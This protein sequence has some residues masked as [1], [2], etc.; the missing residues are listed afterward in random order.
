M[1]E[2]PDAVVLIFTARLFDEHPMITYLST[3]LHWLLPAA[4]LLV[5]VEIHRPPNIRGV[6]AL[7]GR[8][9]F[10]LVAG[11][12]RA[13][14]GFGMLLRDAHA[15]VALGPTILEQLKT[16]DPNLA[17]RALVVPP[18]PLVA[19]PR[20]A[21]AQSRARSRAQLG[22][23]EDVFLLAYFGYVYPG[24]GIETLLA[25]LRLLLDGGRKVCLVM[26]GGGRGLRTDSGGGAHATYE[27]EMVG[28]AQRLGIA[29]EVF[30][31]QGYASGSEDVALDLLAADAAVLPFDDGAELR[32]S[33]IAVVATMGLPLVTT[34][35][36]MAEPAF[37]DEVNAL[38]CRPRDAEE[39]CAAICRLAEDEEL[40][41]RLSAGALALAATWF[42]WDTAI[43]RIAGALHTQAS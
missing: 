4:R 26:A 36:Q 14:Y 20:L 38:M 7:I 28:L 33:S 40:R 43:D 39:L 15:V 17:A 23:G 13:D 29:E 21:D 30:W 35:P 16:H 1:T 9:L 27:D 31:P 6:G 8:K 19:R 24:K 25:A 5:I 34:L 37:V 10:E 32:R 12:R 22:V 2:R 41:M 11:R 18:P 42:S 3:I